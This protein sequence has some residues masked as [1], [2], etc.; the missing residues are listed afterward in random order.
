MNGQEQTKGNSVTS[1]I[2][3]ASPFRFHQEYPWNE[4]FPACIEQSMP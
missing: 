2:V 4:P 3:A 1:V